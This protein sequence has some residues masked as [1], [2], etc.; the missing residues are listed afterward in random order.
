MLNLR[1]AIPHNVTIACL[2]AICFFCDRFFKR[3]YLEFTC[4][5][6]E[7]MPDARRQILG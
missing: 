7:L 1:S 6:I 4:L 5:K 2:D 3:L